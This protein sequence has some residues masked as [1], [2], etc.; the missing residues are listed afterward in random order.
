MTPEQVFSFCNTLV[1]PGWLLLLLLPRWKYTEHIITGIIV[2]ILALLYCYFIFTN[3]QPADFKSFNTLGGVMALFTKDEAVLAGWIHYLAFDMMTG[4]FIVKNAQKHQV[5][6]WLL[7]PCLLLTF[8]LGPCGLLLYFI[9]RIIT[10]RKLI[11][12]NY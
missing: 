5:N 1:L 7:I 12:S 10:T 8:M 2:T 6:H 3:L 4:L 11:P 9:I